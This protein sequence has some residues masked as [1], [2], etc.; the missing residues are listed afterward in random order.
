MRRLQ[1]RAPFTGF[2]TVQGWEPRPR[3]RDGIL[4]YRLDTSVFHRL[5]PDVGLGADT[6]MLSAPCGA[7]VPPGVPRREP[8][9]FAARP[10]ASASP[11]QTEMPPAAAGQD[12]RK[13]CQ[14]RRF[15]AWLGGPALPFGSEVTDGNHSD[16]TVR[17]EAKRQAGK[18][19]HAG[20]AAPFAASSL[21]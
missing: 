21:T 11:K 14:A 2:G 8:G 3:S 6:S 17:R 12:K 1:V 16:F 20:R 5:R 10:R 9:G 18:E 4:F 19:P 13:D 15:R 7:E